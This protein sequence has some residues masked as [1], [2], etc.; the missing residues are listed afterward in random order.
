MKSKDTCRNEKEDEEK[1]DR[2]EKKERNCSVA[3]KETKR[4]ECRCDRSE[5]GERATK[6][7]GYT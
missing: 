2:G 3:K 5:E 7:G 4:S 6:G 1:R